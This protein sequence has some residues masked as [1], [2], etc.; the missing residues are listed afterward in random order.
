MA[1]TVSLDLRASDHD[2]N[3]WSSIDDGD[4]S[5]WFWDAH[6]SRGWGNQPDSGGLA[7]R[8][9]LRE[10]GFISRERLDQP[11]FARDYYL[12]PSRSFAADER[13]GEGTLRLSPLHGLTV[14]PSYGRLS[15]SERFVSEA[16][17]TS[18]RGELGQVAE[19]TARWR[20]V[21]ARPW[22]RL[23]WTATVRLISTWRG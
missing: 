11:D 21:R 6:Y 20:R 17:Q 1:G 19:L 10:S 12:P 13:L 18:A 15:Y 2:R 22:I 8:Y 5:A 23:E 4:N 3:L 9:R 16:L 14:I 7:V